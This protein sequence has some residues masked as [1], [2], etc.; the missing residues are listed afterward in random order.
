MM[1]HI[2]TGFQ[3]TGRLH[4]GNFTIIKWLINNRENNK[5]FVGVMDY[6]AQ[7]TGNEN[8]SKEV[9]N[10]L[11]KYLGHYVYV[12][13]Q[14]DLNKT[15]KGGLLD[16]YWKIM[17]IH[18]L[19]DL[20]NEGH[21]KEKSLKLKSEGKKITPALLTYPLLQC[22]DILFPN[23]VLGI[24]ESIHVPIGKDQTQHL[25]LCRKV[26][27]KLNLPKPTPIVVNDFLIRDLK[28]PEFKMSKSNP[29]G[30][31]FLDDSKDEIFK[32]INSAKTNINN[33]FGFE[34]ENLFNILILFDFP[35]SEI[36]KEQYIKKEINNQ[37][38]KT[39]IIEYLISK[40]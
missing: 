26:A 29:D 28:N 22:A 18:N 40:L 30:C 6:H 19:N 17:T 39:I 38:L 27:K 8:N 34:I 12:Y 10:L 1:K 21:F 14:S 11:E 2:L 16:L 4:I 24:K 35:D 5:L 36:L 13:L 33:E 3:P 25:E 23:Y 32:K 7:T 31:L 37:K 15:N 9:F 20:L